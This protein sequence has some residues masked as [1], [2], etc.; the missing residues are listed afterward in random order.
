MHARIRCMVLWP[1]CVMQSSVRTAA[2]VAGPA[3]AH[4]PAHH[5]LACPRCRRTSADGDPGCHS[6]AGGTGQQADLGGSHAQQAAPHDPGAAQGGPQGLPPPEAAAAGLARLRGAPLAFVSFAN[7]AFNDFLANWVAS[8]QRLGLPFV[9]GALDER[10]A[11]EAAARGWPH[12]LV[13]SAAA[14]GGGDAFFRANFT[15][16][17]GMGAKKVQLVLTMLDRY[18]VQTIVVSDSGEAPGPPTRPHTAPHQTARH[19]PAGARLQPYGRAA[20]LAASHTQPG[21]QRLRPAGC[22]A[23]SGRLW[24]QLRGCMLGQHPARGAGRRNAALP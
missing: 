4:N 22:W 14:T 13:G 21:V 6:T 17:R 15:A 5:V 10:M 3:P 16:F 12:L 11:E 24:E 9:V 2:C 20:W 23:G 8:V 7:G 1:V 18:E 19:P